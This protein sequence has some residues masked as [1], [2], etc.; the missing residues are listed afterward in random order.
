MT[1]LQDKCYLEKYLECFIKSFEY[2]RGALSIRL[3]HLQI[4]NL[5][6]DPNPIPLILI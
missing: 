6:S 4:Q 5:V 2:S 1:I 3:S